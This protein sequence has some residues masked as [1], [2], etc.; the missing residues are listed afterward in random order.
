M[1]SC[2]FC[3]VALREEQRTNRR[4]FKGELCGA[5]L[6]PVEP[7]LAKERPLLV[8]TVWAYRHQGYDRICPERPGALPTYAESLQ[9][10]AWA[11]LREPLAFALGGC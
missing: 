4:L 5:T 9:R 7:V 6:L 8:A 1:R 3:F 2:H 10:F 11:S